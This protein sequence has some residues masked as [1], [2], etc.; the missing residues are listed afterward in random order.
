MGDRV[1]NFEGLD[2]ENWAQLYHA[3]GSGTYPYPMRACFVL[4]VAWLRLR[5]LGKP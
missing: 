5:Q 4:A 2:D 3:Y 1:P